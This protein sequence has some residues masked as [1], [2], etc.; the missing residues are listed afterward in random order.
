[1]ADGVFITLEGIDGVGKT[2]QAQRL[3]KR[4]AAEGYGVVHTREPGGTAIGSKIRSIL[5]DADHKDMVAATEILLYAADRAQHAAQVI[6]PALQ[7]GDWVVCERFI[8]SSLAYQGYGLGW[9]RK[10]I[11]QINQWA[12]LDLTPQLT[13]CLDHDPALALSRAGRDRVEQRTLEYYRK[14]RFGFLDMAAQAPSRWAVISAAGDM[15]H[16]EL[17][18]WEQV[19]RRLM[20]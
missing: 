17:L 12:V 2:T 15:D 10:A 11:A 20:L 14:E 18:V 16:I 3:Q 19:Q 7:R 6:L 8:D 5:L 13:I 4:I 1:M 9:D